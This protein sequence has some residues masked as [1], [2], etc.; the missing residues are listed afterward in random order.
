VRIDFSDLKLNKQQE[1]KELTLRYSTRFIN[2]LI[3]TCLVNRILSLETLK[4]YLIESFPN[5]QF[6]PQNI[7]KLALIGN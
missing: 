1:T 7:K 2:P 5:L 6:I 3:T 4:V